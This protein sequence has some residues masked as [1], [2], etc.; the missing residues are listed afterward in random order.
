MT[1]ISTLATTGLQPVAVPAEDGNLPPLQSAGFLGRRQELQ[2]I[3]RALIKNGTRCLSITGIGGQ[4][5]TY[6]A[7]EAGQRL[8]RSQQFQKICFVDY[9]AS[10]RVDAVD[11]AVKTL[12]LV[13]D[14]NLVNVATITEALAKTSTLVILDHLDN[15]PAEQLQ[16]LLE[17]VVQWAKVGASRVLI[18]IHEADFKTVFESTDHNLNYHILPLSGFAKKDA[19]AYFQRLWELPPAPQVK[20]PKSAELLSLFKQVAFHPL[21]IGLLAIPLKAF[22]PTVLEE[23]LVGLLA[24]TPDDPFWAV[25]NLVLADLEVE[26]EKSGWLYWLARLLGRRTTQ[27]VRLEA[28]TL[29]LLPRLGVFQGGAFEPDLLEITQFAQKQ[30]RI[31]RSTLEAAG[32]IQLEFLPR[33]RGPFLKFHPILASTLWCRFSSAEEQAFVLSDYQQRYAQ[34]AAY[35]AYEEG[36]NTIQVHALT[37]RNL[38][39]LLYAVHGAF[40]GGETWAVQFA[41]NLNI[42]LNYYGFRR[43]SAALNQRI[44][45]VG[46]KL[47]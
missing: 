18:T 7:I 14:D 12:A 13:L 6:L 46:E 33:F 37:R 11:L 26:I 24:Q 38:S 20:V 16:E 23:R 36:K 39:N 31:L 15:I 4:G 47:A 45:D 10:S 1:K 40:D 2:Q 22:Q 9:A 8:Y 17:A 5:K 32:L 44:E 25:L 21:S 34:L 3:E 29:R 19:L 30:W 42:F 41:K 35:M 27:K 43:D 28:K